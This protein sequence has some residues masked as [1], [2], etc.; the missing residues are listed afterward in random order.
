MKLMPHFKFQYVANHLHA[1]N[2]KYTCFLRPY[3]TKF[4]DGFDPRKN[5]FEDLHGVGI[6]I[7]KI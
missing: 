5:D 1:H 6:S 7:H 4:I 2:V 3:T